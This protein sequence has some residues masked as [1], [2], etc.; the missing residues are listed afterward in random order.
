MIKYAVI[1]KHVSPRF[2]FANE[3]VAVK[4]S[5]GRPGY[6][7]AT[8]TLGC[9]KDYPSADRAA[10]AMFEDNCCTVIQ[11]ILLADMDINAND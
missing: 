5:P 4:Q 1:A 11:I 9:S 10:R 3:I 7:Y 8:G 6:W 2:T